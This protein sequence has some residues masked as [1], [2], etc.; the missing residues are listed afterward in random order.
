MSCSHQM[1]VSN[2][3]TDNSVK[4]LSQ[5]C[6]HLV[7]NN[8]NCFINFLHLDQHIIEFSLKCKD[9]ED[10]MKLVKAIDWI[11]SS[12][13][14]IC[15]KIGAKLKL[16]EIEIYGSDSSA[17]N[18]W[19][20][21]FNKSIES[22]TII[23]TFGTQI[24]DNFLT[25]FQSKPKLFHLISLDLSHNKL[26]SI[27]LNGMTSLRSLYLENNYL[28]TIKEFDNKITTISLTRNEWICDKNLIWLLKYTKDRSHKVINRENILCK[29]PEVAKDMK[30][31][32]R[33]TVLETPICGQCECSVVRNKDV[34]SVNCSNNQLESLPTSLPSITKIVKLDNNNIK[35]ISLNALALN[36][37]RNV[38]YLHLNNNTIES[39]AGFERT[40]LL[41]NLVALHLN[42]NRLKE[43]P[44]YILDQLSHLDELYLSN[45]PWLCNCKTVVFQT[46]LQNHFKNVK[47]VYNIRCAAALDPDIET[48]PKN[49]LYTENADQ[50]F[51]TRVLLR[52][53][54]SELCPQSR[55]PIEVFEIINWLVSTLIILIIIKLIYDYFWQKRTGKLPEFFKLNI[56]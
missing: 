44:V 48:K 7:P 56:N 24:D 23:E 10:H 50:K 15:G 25:K 2:D 5:R 34:M 31:S 30:F 33:M 16:K 14:S 18:Q 49:G 21:T 27:D 19:L 9:I 53:P 29:S 37:W 26:E 38:S 43:I 8:D 22:L 52:I 20:K 42:N 28:K 36:N 40:N 47:D 35:H 6:I 45:N 12:N 41:K 3:I 1:V 11:Y 46:W 13:D 55:E 32:Q 4:E 39:L 54:K 17:V 51:A